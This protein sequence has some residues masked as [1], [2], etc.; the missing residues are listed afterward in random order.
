MPRRYKD[1]LTL[2]PDEN[3]A[4]IFTVPGGDGTTVAEHLGAA[5]ALLET[6]RQA[7]RTTGYLE[8]EA[9]DASVEAAMQDSG[10]GPWPAAAKAGREQL[11][12][13]AES[14]ADQLEGMPTS[15]WSRSASGPS[16]S[17]TMSQLAQGGVRVLAGRLGAIERVISQVR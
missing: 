8:A 5:I 2:P 15:S 16:G 3:V 6:L 14:F 1:A 17:I 4:D 11:E 10:T 9:L 13:I 7:A 12:E